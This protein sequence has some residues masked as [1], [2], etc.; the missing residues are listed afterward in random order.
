MGK[1]RLIPFPIL[2]AV[3][4]CVLGF[5]MWQ[6][7][8]T[9]TMV[10]TS[11]RKILSPQQLLAVETDALFFDKESVAR[12]ACQK[13]DDKMHVQQ[14]IAANSSQLFL[15]C[16]DALETAQEKVDQ[17]ACNDDDDDE[18]LLIHMY[19]ADGPLRDTAALSLRSVLHS[20]PKD[21]FQVMLWTA[22]ADTQQMLRS[23]LS[24]YNKDKEVIVVQPL[25]S[26]NLID[27]MKTNFPN[28]ADTITAA[29]G[30]LSDFNG[31][32]ARKVSDGVRVMVLAAYGGIYLDFD[33]LL[34]RSL[35]PLAK[36]D[37]FYRWS[38]VKSSNTAVFGLQLASP[39]TAALLVKPLQLAKDFNDLSERFH[40]HSIFKL[41]QETNSSVDLLPSAYFDPLWV[42]T[43]GYETAKPSAEQRYGL[44]TFQEMFDPGR[45]TIQTTAFFPGA[46]VFHW[47]NQWG[48]QIVNKSIA[49]A[50]LNYYDSKEAAGM[51]L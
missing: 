13:L 33:C 16:M 38:M 12:Q 32:N 46:F 8:T 50:F 19:W 25:N 45:N 39:N 17:K 3:A 23:N 22:S 2:L 47:H 18:P 10:L 40:P 43:D 41:V 4:C 9:M 26:T 31:A 48:K 37:F 6:Q 15:D 30:V 7:T 11:N 28:I 35:Q 49:G 27:R 42:V 36:H 34:L 29:S 20:Q 1:V 44:E 21:C 14:H 5:V 51:I 24:K